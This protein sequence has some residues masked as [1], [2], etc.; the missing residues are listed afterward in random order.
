[1]RLLALLLCSAALAS[2]TA[3]RGCKLSPFDATWPVDAEWAALNDSISGSLIKTI[4]AASSCYKTNPFNALRLSMPTSPSRFH[5]HYT[6]TIP[7][8]LLG[9]QVTTKRLAVISVDIQVML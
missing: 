6:P 9:L 8:Y 2:S 5:P 4:P 1:M 3:T 7:V